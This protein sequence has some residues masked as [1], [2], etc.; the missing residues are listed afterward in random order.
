MFKKHSFQVKLVKDAP[1]PDTDPVCDYMARLH[2][3]GLEADR[4]V[5]STV[6]AVVTVV[7]VKAAAELALHIAE[8][9]IK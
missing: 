3:T 6:K 5:Q 8:T 2:A 9:Y 1:V 4:L 7:V